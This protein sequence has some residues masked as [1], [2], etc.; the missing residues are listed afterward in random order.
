MDNIEKLCEAA[1]DWDLETVRR[2][3]DDKGMDL[4][5]LDEMDGVKIPLL[6]LAI[7]WGHS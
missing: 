6:S 4:N 1:Y 3:V 2:L 7:G 5:A